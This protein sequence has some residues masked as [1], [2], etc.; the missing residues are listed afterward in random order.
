MYPPPPH[1][2]PLGRPKINKM[3]AM[4]VLKLAHMYLFII[5]TF[6]TKLINKIVISSKYKKI[7][8]F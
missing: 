7:R 4:K 1:R 8:R 2:N 5:V 3:C 6:V